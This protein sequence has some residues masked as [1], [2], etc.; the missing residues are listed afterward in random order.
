VR[1]EVEHLIARA[2]PLGIL[3]I[4]GRLVQLVGQGPGAAP[5]GVEEPVVVG[6]I[7]NP[8]YLGPGGKQA[9][10]VPERRKAVAVLLGFA[11]Q[12]VCPTGAGYADW[13]TLSGRWDRSR[14][15]ELR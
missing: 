6:R 5:A 3:E 10:E 4:V 8:S 7:A 15:A 2:E 11:E 9:V 1:L 12:Q 13:L 14:L